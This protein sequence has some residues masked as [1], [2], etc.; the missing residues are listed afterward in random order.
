MTSDE[1][2]IYG[3]VH[4][5][6][7]GDQNRVEIVL[8]PGETVPFMAPT[9]PLYELVGRGDVLDG[10]RRSVMLGKDSALFALNGIPGIGKTALAVA[11]SHDRQVGAAFRGGVLWAGLGPDPDLMMLLGQWGAALGIPAEQLA[12]ASTLSSRAQMIHTAIGLRRMLLV[13]DDAWSIDAALT[14]RL[15]GPNSVHLLTSRIPEVAARFALHAVA[16]QELDPAAGFELLVRLAPDACQIDPAGARELVDLVAGLPLALVLLGNA[17]RV[18]STGGSRRRVRETIAQL[19]DAERRLSVSEPRGIL[20]AHQDAGSGTSL[21][22]LASIQLSDEALGPAGQRALR[23]ITAFPAKPNSF[24]EEAAANV[25]PGGLDDVELLMD[26]GMLES[27]GVDRYTLH[28][29]IHDY[30]SRDGPSPPAR[31]RLVR[32]YVGALEA[33]AEAASDAAYHG[34][35]FGTTDTRDG[36]D[37]SADTANVLAALDAAHWLGRWPEL[38]SGVNEFA[39]HLNRRGLLAQA[40]MHL[41]RALAVADEL[42]DIAGRS[43]TRINLAG[44]FQQQGEL[45]RA[46]AMLEDGLRLARATDLAGLRYDA[47]LR[48]GWVLGRLGEVSS[49]KA[50]FAE[51][52]GVHDGRDR[53]GARAAVLQGMGSLDRVHGLHD[54]SA[55]NLRE[56]LAAARRLGEAYQ[57]ADILQ[58]LGWTEG[59]R[60]RR[61]EAQ[62][63]FAE[64]AEMS[65]KG[66]FATVLVNALNGLGWL[67]GLR[68]DYSAARTRFEEA[69]ALAEAT[70]YSERGVLMGSLAWVTREDGEFEAAH[71]MFQE[72]L[73]WSREKG[74][75]EKTA[76]FLGKLAELEVLL[77]RLDDAEAHAL[78]SIAVAHA[79]HFPDRLVQPLCTLAAIARRRGRPESSLP[80]LDEATM[81]ARAIG[82]DFLLAEVANERASVFLEM[83]ELDA[84]ESSLANAED[85]AARADAGD[86]VGRALLARAKVALARDDIDRARALAEDAISVLSRTSP[87]QARDASA[88]RDR[89]GGHPA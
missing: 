22:L 84:A 43:R 20:D 18:Q 21:S 40:Q 76:L 34:A 63:A 28:Q 2:G 6:V 27:A 53:S 19:R 3:P 26:L 55:R 85:Y 29:T 74:E 51:A 71:A 46:K 42:D 60:G 50:A 15:G 17:L 33:A 13:I 49:A 81:H 64:A 37:W 77:H 79:Q 32:Y 23:D 11:L 7:L 56:A 87:A 12:N 25:V 86:V 14:F 1:Y 52:L 39:E 31:E 83:G 24:T 61:A 59:M 38:V 69:F 62:E 70:G 78:E 67:D 89:L 45:R 80:V 30:A 4:G 35:E 44:I 16:V 36:P 8:P 66:N 73:A 57:V 65:R 72:S 75:V 5:L 10:L 41:E 9:R 54:T 58:S 47:L 68:G 82:N 88:W 48:L